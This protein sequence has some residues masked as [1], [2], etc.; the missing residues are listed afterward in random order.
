MNAGC[1]SVLV[2]TGYGMETINVLQKQNK[3]PSFVAENLMDAVNFIIKD[4]SGVK[5][6]A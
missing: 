5:I 2:K 3:F 6:G 4:L 1:K